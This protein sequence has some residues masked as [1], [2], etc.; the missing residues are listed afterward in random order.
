VGIGPENL[1]EIL[2]EKLREEL[3]ARSSFSHGQVTVGITA[4][5]LPSASAVKGVLVKA[6][7]DNTGKVYVGNSSTVTTSTGFE[8]AAGEAVVIEVDNANRIW[9]IA[10]AADQKISWIAV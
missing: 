8:L 5:Q 9:V 2:K 6:H 10:D 3:G 1:R 7:K 4:V